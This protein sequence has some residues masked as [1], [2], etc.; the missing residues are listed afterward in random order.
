MSRAQPL[1]ERDICV[2][3]AGN[4]CLPRTSHFITVNSSLPLPL[5]VPPPGSHRSLTQMPPKPPETNEKISPN[6]V[7]KCP[8]ENISDKTA[9]IF[10]LCLVSF[11]TEMPENGEDNGQNCRRSRLS[12]MLPLLSPAP[13][14]VKVPILLHKCVITICKSLSPLILVKA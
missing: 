14:F 9:Q 5:P 8:R 10:L 2:V 13:P 1:P 6:T 4:H 3:D 7:E 12:K 11:V